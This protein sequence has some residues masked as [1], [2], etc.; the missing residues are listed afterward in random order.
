MKNDGLTVFSSWQGGSF[1]AMLYKELQPVDV[2]TIQ[3]VRP[4]S[5]Y[6]R[7]LLSS[8]YLP[9]IGPDATNLYFTFWTDGEGITSNQFTHY[10]LM[11]VL[12]M[13]LPQVFQAR[14]VLEAIGL[15]RTLQKEELN[16][17]RFYYEVSPPLDAKTFFEDPLLSTFFFSKVGEAA[18]R[19]ARN[20][21]V[22]DK[23]PTE[24]FTDISRT[25][26][27]VFTA[28]S[29]R[30]SITNEE[31]VELQGQ[32]DAK[33]L[34]F[35][36][37]SFDYDL[38]RQ[39]LSEQM[40]PRKTLASVPELF[41][42]KLAFLYSLTPIDMQKVVM[43]ALDDQLQITEDRLRRAAADFYKMNMSKEPPQLQASIK[44]EPP[45][46][47]ESLSQEEELY[48]Y[49]DHTPPREMLRHILNKEPFSVDVQLAER[50]VNTHGLPVGVVNVLL[51]YVLLRNNMK[52]TN[53]FA[54]R[55]G[56]HWAHA[57]VKNAKEA[58]ELSRKEHDQYMN[59]L[60][61]G[62]PKATPRKKT[63][64]EEKVPE[65]FYKKQSNNQKSEQEHFDV[66]IERRK[67]LEELGVSDKEVK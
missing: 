8:L 38:L 41:I 14:I 45:K 5:S 48:Y 44:V 32:V 64:R 29:H 67:L 24:D 25:F 51:Q 53:S 47:F 57:K 15:L 6:D 1:E 62:K 28:S 37:Y 27:D 36:N 9:L 56:S 12:S 21:F 22:I 4:L 43:L 20:R 18:Y 31:G 11:N 7:Q 66:D 65:W 3:L 52:I 30:N 2:Y 16:E 39:G 10:H 13:P 23:L 63:T 58:I 59:W 34:P 50:M 54:E 42:A 60:N 61:E 35:A 49:L 17:R 19:H 26:L 55:I 46:S 33:S 40:V